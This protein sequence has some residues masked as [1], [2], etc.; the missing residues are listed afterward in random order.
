LNFQIGNVSEERTLTTFPVWKMQRA[1]NFYQ[2]LNAKEKEKV[3]AFLR[4]VGGKEA[5][6][7]SLNFRLIRKGFRVVADGKS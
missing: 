2:S 3:D 5:M 4:E 1:L 6:Q 7:L